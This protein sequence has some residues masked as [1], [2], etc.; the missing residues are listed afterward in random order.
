MY[1]LFRARRL[2]GADRL[3]SARPQTL[4]AE[5]S[6]RG[7][8]FEVSWRQGTR[9]AS[10]LVW[11]PRPRAR[12]S[13]RRAQVHPSWPGSGARPRQVGEPMSCV[14]LSTGQRERI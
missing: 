3:V 2:A 10:L 12:E 14:L 1:R 9:G 4:A 5:C 13:F 11:R 7:M 6:D 8:K